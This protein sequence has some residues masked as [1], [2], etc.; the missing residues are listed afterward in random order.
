MQ[1]LAEKRRF[2]K[3]CPIA[4]IAEPARFKRLFEG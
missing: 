3:K 2:L 4:L 1:H